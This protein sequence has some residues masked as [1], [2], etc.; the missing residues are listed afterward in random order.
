MFLL[1]IIMI[2]RLN[3]RLNSYLPP[4]S[5]VLHPVIRSFVRKLTY[6]LCLSQRRY[7]H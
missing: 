6:I 1:S 7:N 4:V 2:N 3:H 5:S